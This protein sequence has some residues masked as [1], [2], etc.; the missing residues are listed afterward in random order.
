MCT[1]CIVLNRCF[2]FLQMCAHA[3]VLA[4]FRLLAGNVNFQHSR[5]SVRSNWSILPFWVFTSACFGLVRN[6]YSKIL[7]TSKRKRNAWPAAFHNVK[8]L[9]FIRIINRLHYRITFRCKI[10]S[11]TSVLLYKAKEEY[12]WFSITRTTPAFKLEC[13]QI[14]RN[15]IVVISNTVKNIM[16]LKSPPPKSFPDDLYYNENKWYATLP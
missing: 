1:N 10:N 11:N 4:E 13:N 16:L 12:I 8:G 7:F 14:K 3:V 15:L 6:D 5:A 2:P 9:H